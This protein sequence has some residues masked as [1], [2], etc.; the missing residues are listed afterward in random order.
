MAKCTMLWCLFLYPLSQ[1]KGPA[2]QQGRK[3]SDY[4][5]AGYCLH[6]GVSHFAFVYVLIFTFYYFI[7]V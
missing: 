1:L 7:E 3:A 5:R 6:G 4:K 2:A